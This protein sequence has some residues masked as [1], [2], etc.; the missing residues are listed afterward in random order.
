MNG[1]N[2]LR[3]R[4]TSLEYCE[5]LKQLSQLNLS[6]SYNV[7]HECCTSFVTKA[8]FTFAAHFRMWLF[9]RWLKSFLIAHERVT[10]GPDETKERDRVVNLCGKWTAHASR[11]L[12]SQRHKIK[13]QGNV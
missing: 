11:H 4:D 8:N 10:F 9:V 13:R 1:F 5:F 2:D 3:P 7:A 6:V 12:P